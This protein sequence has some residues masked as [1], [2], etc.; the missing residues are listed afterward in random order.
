[1]QVTIGCTYSNHRAVRG[2]RLVDRNNGLTTVCDIWL[3]KCGSTTIRSMRI[4]A[5]KLQS[6]PF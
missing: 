2:Y 6:L 4:S 3:C 1:M 5:T